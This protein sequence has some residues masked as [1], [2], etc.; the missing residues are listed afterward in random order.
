MLIFWC[1]IQYCIANLVEDKRSRRVHSP[2]CLNTLILFNILC[3]KHT[4]HVV[5]PIHHH[6]GKSSRKLAKEFDII[7]SN[8]CAKPNAMMVKA[9][10]T[11]VTLPAMLRLVIDNCVTNV[12][13]VLEFVTIIKCFILLL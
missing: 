4:Y 10:D 7:F 6:K 9:F 13:I 12:A 1:H 2:N 8:A 11:L 3:V 5:A